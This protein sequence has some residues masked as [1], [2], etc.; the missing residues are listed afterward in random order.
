MTQ[1]KPGHTNGPEPSARHELDGGD[2]ADWLANVHRMIRFNFVRY[3]I[4]LRLYGRR[5]RPQTIDRAQ[6]AALLALKRKMKLSTRGCEQVLRSR[7]ALL[8]AIGLAET[9][10]H[11]F[12]SRAEESVT[13][14]NFRPQR[15]G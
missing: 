9:P 14:I 4:P 15:V 11:M 8:A 2:L 13:Q 1:W 6:A 7:P 10:S 12:F 3:G 5:G